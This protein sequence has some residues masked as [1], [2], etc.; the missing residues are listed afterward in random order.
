MIPWRENC[1]V[2]MDAGDEDDGDD[3]A[4]ADDADGDDFEIP[5]ENARRSPDSFRRSSLSL[6]RCVYCVQVCHWFYSNQELVC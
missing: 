3:V 5:D 1:K 2:S 6:S 4:A